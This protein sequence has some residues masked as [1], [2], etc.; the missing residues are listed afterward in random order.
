[1]TADSREDFD[2]K[3]LIRHCERSEAMTEDTP[4]HSR[5]TIMSGHYRAHPRKNRRAQRDPQV[6]ARGMPDARRAPAVR[7]QKVVSTRQSPQVQ[8]AGRHS[9]RNGVTAYSALSPVIGRSCHRHRR[10]TKYRRQFERQRRGVKTTRL[11]RPHRHASS[12]RADPSIAFRPT[13]VTIAIRPS[14][15]T[16]TAALIELI[17]AKREAEYFLREGWTGKSANSL[18]GQIS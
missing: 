4:P 8:P 10:D 6:R 7:V 17:L 2:F 3:Q 12:W 18:V 15:R 13:S 5:D 11:R 16:G 14:W 1:M 9:P